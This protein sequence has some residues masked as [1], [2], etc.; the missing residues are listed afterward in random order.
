MGSIQDK[1]KTYNARVHDGE[2]RLTLWQ[3]WRIVNFAYSC[4]PPTLSERKAGCGTVGHDIPANRF[5]GICH[6]H[7]AAVNLCNDLVR[8]N[9]CHT[10]LVGKSKQ[11]AQELC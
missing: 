10:E 11:L 7:G 5:F 2:H 6:K 1:K 9:D 4:V 8:D 3:V